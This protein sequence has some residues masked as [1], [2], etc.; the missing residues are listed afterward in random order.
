MVAGRAA[1]PQGRLPVAISIASCCR[2][3]QK[4]SRKDRRV[5]PAVQLPSAATRHGKA[6]TERPVSAAF[7]G[8]FR[9]QRGCISWLGNAAEQGRHGA[10]H[11]VL[12]VQDVESLNFL[13][14]TIWSIGII[15]YKLQRLRCYHF[16]ASGNHN[17][18]PESMAQ[19]CRHFLSGY[20]TS[21]Q[22]HVG[23]NI[24]L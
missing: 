8:V 16:S 19:G 14:N 22:D 4:G 9:G 23:T 24:E 10:P 21:A 3:G 7:N 15:T 6:A 1:T 17:N 12:D 20:L 11:R 18:R 2:G 13:P 5:S